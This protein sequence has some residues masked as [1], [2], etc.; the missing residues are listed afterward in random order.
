MPTAARTTGNHVL[1]VMVRSDG[2]NEDGG[3]NDAHKE[4]RGLIGV[5]YTGATPTATWKIQGNKGGETPADT[6]RGA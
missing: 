6:V 3:V 2:H 4:G 1:S 5:A